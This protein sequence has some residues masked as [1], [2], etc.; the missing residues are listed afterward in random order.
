[1]EDK[2]TKEEVKHVAHLARI[3]IDENEMENYQ[4]KL[5]Q[6]MDGI[7][8]IDDIKVADEDILITPINHYCPLRE[9]VVGVM[10]DAKTAL[11]NVPHKS[12]NFIDVPLILESK[13]SE[14]AENE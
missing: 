4:I 6:L 3:E 7:S 11:K 13:D 9:D 8:K 12:G 14:V 2:L 5:K 1:M 10:L